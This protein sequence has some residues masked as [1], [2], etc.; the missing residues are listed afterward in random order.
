MF[1]RYAQVSGSI[2]IGKQNI[3]TAKQII[4]SEG[5]SILA[6]DVGGLQGR[7]IFFYTDNGEVYLKRLLKADSADII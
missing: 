2:L 5:L 6:M 7:K 1:S 4:L 3:Q